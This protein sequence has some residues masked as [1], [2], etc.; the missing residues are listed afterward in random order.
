MKSNNSSIKLAIRAI[1]AKAIARKEIS[2][3]VPAYKVKHELLKESDPNTKKISLDVDS[4]YLQALEKEKAFLND[5][6]SGK[7][8]SQTHNLLKSW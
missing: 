1:R 8:V 7:K 6:L 2:N 5:R 4:I 3:F